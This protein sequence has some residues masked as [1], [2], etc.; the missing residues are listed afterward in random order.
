MMKKRRKGSKI[1]VYKLQG[2]C[3]I[4][5]YSRANTHRTNSMIKARMP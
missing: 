4:Y 5:K 3:T 1:V 2:Q